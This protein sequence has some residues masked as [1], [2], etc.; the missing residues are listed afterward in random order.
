MA[1]SAARHA[2]TQ[3]APTFAV[4][5][6]RARIQARAHLNHEHGILSACINE[7]HPAMRA[8]RQVHW[9]TVTGGGF[10][11]AAAA[12]GGREPDP[13]FCHAGRNGYD[14]RPFVEYLVELK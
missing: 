12:S 5:R 11:P 7:H 14:D 9:T 6:E 8:P 13:A 10:L 2:S 4:V 3:T 1:R